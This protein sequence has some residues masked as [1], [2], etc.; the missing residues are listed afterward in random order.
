MVFFL[1]KYVWLYGRFQGSHFFRKLFILFTEILLNS[2]VCLKD[3]LP[4]LKA[5]FFVLDLH[6]KVQGIAKGPR[7]VR[8]VLID[9]RSYTQKT[10][11]GP[12]V[13]L[14]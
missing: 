2:R 4:K 10:F 11:F 6:K 13:R 14:W 7:A 1:N 12:P 3:P 9:A 8:A 5:C